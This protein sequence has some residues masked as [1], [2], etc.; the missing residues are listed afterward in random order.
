ML[1]NAPNVLIQGAYGRGNFGDDALMVA[2]DAVARHA[3]PADSPQ[4]LSRNTSYLTKLLASPRLLSPEDRNKTAVD[5]LLYGGGTQFYSFPRTTENLHHRILHYLRKPKAIAQRLASAIS[6][7]AASPSEA[8]RTAAIGLGLGP[9]CDT[10][11]ERC[12][13]NLVSR[14]EYAAVR[15]TAS[16]ALCQQWGCKNAVLR[17][18]A[19]YL[20]GL[21]NL[22]SPRPSSTGIRRIGIIPRDWPHTIEGD[23]YA[24]AMFDA[25]TALRANGKD[26]D[27]VLFAPTYDQ[28]WQ[29]RLAKRNESPIVWDPERNDISSFLVSLSAYDAFITARYHGAVFAS[30]LGKPMICIGVERKLELAASLFGEGARLWSHPFN[31]ASCLKHVAD[32]DANH[33]RCEA[34]MKGIVAN[35]AALAQQMADEL[36]AL[37]RRSSEGP[38]FPPHQRHS[39]PNRCETPRT[40]RSSR[41]P[42]GV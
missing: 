12:A 16:Y 42:V 13:M 10:R 26:V 39:Q 14:M 30:I 40:G 8:A 38:P 33:S 37:F 5:I 2:V 11:S 17:A 1:S 29:R 6:R 20:P 32:L 9:F 19:C 7:K 34:A 28:Q 22:P 36:V 15:D 25:V 23:S 31:A 18:D 21:W 3:F 35:Q 24:A 27:Y 41:P 4:Y